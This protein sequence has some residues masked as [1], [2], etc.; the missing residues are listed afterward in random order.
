MEAAQAA[1]PNSH[2]RRNLINCC[3]KELKILEKVQSHEQSPEPSSYWEQ[4]QCDQ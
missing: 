1:I 4:L 2:I 3:S